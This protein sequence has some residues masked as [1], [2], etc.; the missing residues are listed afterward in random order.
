[1]RDVCDRVLYDEQVSKPLQRLR[2]E[3]LGL[4]GDV[5]T[6]TEA[7]ETPAASS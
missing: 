4:V 7:D 6:R 5:Y 2:A 3:A 1:M